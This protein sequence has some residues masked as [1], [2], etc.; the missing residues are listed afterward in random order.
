MLDLAKLNRHP[1]SEIR[2]LKLRPLSI[3][4]YFGLIIEKNYSILP[5]DMC[6]IKETFPIF[7][8]STIHEKLTHHSNLCYVKTAFC[9]D[10]VLKCAKFSRFLKYKY[11]FINNRYF[12]T[13]CFSLR[14][15]GVQGRVSLEC[16]CF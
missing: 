8:Y 4:P 1:T 7:L 12:L 6:K 3:F 13:H 16:A 9:L 15:K 2:Y 11:V 14:S 10:F 5:S